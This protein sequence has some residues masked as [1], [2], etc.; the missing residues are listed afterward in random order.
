MRAGKF[1][2]ISEESKR[3]SQRAGVR[4]SDMVP[5]LDVAFHCG[6]FSSHETCLR[7]LKAGGLRLDIVKFAESGFIQGL[8]ALHKSC[9]EVLVV[10]SKKKL[11]ELVDQLNLL[12][13]NLLDERK[14]PKCG[15]LCFEFIGEWNEVAQIS[16][17]LKSKVTPKDLSKFFPF[18]KE[19][20]LSLENGPHITT[21]SRQ[22]FPVSFQKGN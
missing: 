18:K 17:S 5:S 14:I 15:F 11:W 8:E 1:T 12:D 4:L 19:K 2:E 22:L 13:S 16:L 6:D 7:A 21:I 3:N 20:K 10:A 9:S